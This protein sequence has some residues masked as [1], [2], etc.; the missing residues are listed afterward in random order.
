M[1]RRD[2][3]SIGRLLATHR[4]DYPGDT[5][6]ASEILDDFTLN[7][8][9]RADEL[10]PGESTVT[11]TQRQYVE[12]LAVEARLGDE[13]A[14]QRL[15]E[16]DPRVAGIVRRQNTQ[17]QD[18]H[19]AH[20]LYERDEETRAHTGLDANGDALHPSVHDALGDHRCLYGD[21]PGDADGN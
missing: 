2:P 6:K 9:G 3:A 7:I 10:D 21:D 12:D 8:M 5:R 16:I 20:M 1:D 4:R 17:A 18:N 11:S 15:L 19:R 14:F 13:N